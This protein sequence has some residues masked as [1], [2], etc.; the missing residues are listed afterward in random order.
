MV[1]DGYGRQTCELSSSSSRLR[2]LPS[3]MVVSRRKFRVVLTPASLLT[4]YHHHRH[5]DARYRT[6]QRCTSKLLGCVPSCA[7]V[8]STLVFRIAGKVFL[9]RH[10]RRSLASRVPVCGLFLRAEKAL[11]TIFLGLYLDNRRFGSHMVQLL[12]VERRGAHC[13]SRG[14]ELNQLLHS[15][16]RCLK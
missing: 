7:A 9:W 12:G 6:L 5:L 2:S 8:T 13:S 10:R 3:E 15:R 16:L 4:S 1:V 14:V 11:I